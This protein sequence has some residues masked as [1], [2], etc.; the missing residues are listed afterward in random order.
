[1][2]FLRSA[3]DIIGFLLLSLVTIIESM[4][5][6]FIPKRYKMKSVA[7]DIALVTG[8][9]GGL[10][11]LLSLRLANLGATVVVWDIN[12]NG[13]DET[14][15]L[16]RAA[17]G[18]CYGYVC[19]LCN[20]EDVYKKAEILKSEVGQV[21]ILINNAGIAT[22]KK[23]MDT[24][25]ELI[26]KTMEVNT[27]AHFWTVKAF[28][29]AMMEKNK[30]HIVSIAS[31]AGHIGVPKLVDYCASKFAA[32]GFDEALRMEL[33]ADGYNKI[34]TTVICPY[35]IR[36][37][38]MF[39]DV[40]SRYNI[41]FRFLLPLS[42]NVVAD[43]VITAIRCNEKFAILPGYFQGLLAAKW[44][45]PWSCVAMFLRGL[46]RDASPEHDQPKKATDNNHQEFEPSKDPNGVLHQQL[47]RR[48]SSSERKP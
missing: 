31:L 30:G 34:Y 35:F 23:F 17:G 16:V 37:T 42:P 6:A 25:D 44:I 12:E 22:G 47:A 9:G 48:V 11:R 40:V 8:G 24:P 5:K 10:G 3:G 28:L 20:R 39:E 27:M 45:F 21:S 14:V 46:V 4:F 41:E 36:A 2:S 1:M 29:P 18:T 33:E 38:G 7:G 15:K 19:N 26:S 13:I 32:V 43:R